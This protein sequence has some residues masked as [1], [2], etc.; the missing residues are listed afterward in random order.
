MTPRIRRS[1]APAGLRHVAVLTLFAFGCATVRAPASAIPA[2]VPV[3]GGMAEPQLELW[4]ESGRAVSPAESAEASAQAKAAL[5]AALSRAPAPQGDAFLVVRA[6]G[7]ART[8]SRRTDQRAA[9]AG[10]VVGAVV[11]V[12]AVVAILVASRG[13]GGG[14]APRMASPRPAPAP[15]GMPV[16]A[17]PVF[18]PRPV[19]PVI[20]VDVSAGV[21][22]P[23]PVGEMPAQAAYAEPPPIWYG[24]QPAPPWT[25]PPELA[26]ISLPPPP[27]LD[28]DRR[29]FF[30]GDTLRLELFVVDRGSGAPIWTKVVDGEVDPRDAQAV[31]KLLSGALAD[32]SGWTPAG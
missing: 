30:E 12:V 18:V 24:A 10:L 25:L 29:G 3:K 17:P 13:K 14:S 16:R 23:L 15:G 32:S 22:V 27:P 4:L 2:T 21:E 11:V 19:H 31:E 1:A 8:A 28:L 26:S 6:Q 5:E 20:A 7:V 9:V